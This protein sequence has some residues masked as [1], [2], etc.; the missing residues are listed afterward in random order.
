MIISI[1][2]VLNIVLKRMF[3]LIYFQISVL[4]RILLI[5]Q[6]KN[7]ILIKMQ[8]LIEYKTTLFKINFI[9]I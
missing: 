6:I 4:Y 1:F 7:T 2:I 3:D 8:L 5:D 9:K